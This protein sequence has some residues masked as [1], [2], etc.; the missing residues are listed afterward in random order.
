MH[1][2]VEAPPAYEGYMP[3]PCI[4]QAPHEEAL[5]VFS[6]TAERPEILSACSPGTSRYHKMPTR[7]A[8]AQGHT[9]GK[10]QIT[11]ASMPFT[12]FAN[13]Q[14]LP[15]RRPGVHKDHHPGRKYM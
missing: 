12:L 14:K 8:S 2:R 3:P 10:Q 13:G 4:S 9:S 11:A 7:S 1:E 5:E 15:D 6:A